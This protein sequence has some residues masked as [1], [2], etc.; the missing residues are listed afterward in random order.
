MIRTGDAGQQAGLYV[1]CVGPRGEAGSLGDIG[2]EG[3]EVYAIAY[4]DLCALVHRSPAEPYQSRDGQAVASWVLAHHRVVDDAWKRWGAVLPLTF[5]TII[6]VAP[7]TDA[8]KGLL[9]WMETEYQP[10]KAKLDALAGKEEYGVQV[11]WDPQ[12]VGR[13]VAR[14][15]P[16]IRMLED[17]IKAK[18]RGLAYMYRQK[19]EALLKNGIE[20]RAAQ[21]CAALCDK[22]SQWVDDLRVEKTKGDPGRLQMLMNLSCLVSREKR[23]CLKAEMDR[24]SAANDLSVRVAGP[25]PPYS[26]C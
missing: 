17:E 2:I 13:E 10:L 14:S 20:A 6:P 9:A 11:F 4:N 19:L 5:N 24:V 15:S 1:Y 25:M 3:R 26:F 16:E 12:A 7:G 22:M 8:G 21:E 18:P 23:P